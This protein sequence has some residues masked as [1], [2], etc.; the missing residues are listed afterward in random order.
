MSIR[1][2]YT[3]KYNATPK[4]PTMEFSMQ[5]SATEPAHN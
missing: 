2:I 4:L 1:Y 3:N 5:P